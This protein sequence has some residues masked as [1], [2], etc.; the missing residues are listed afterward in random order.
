MTQANKKVELYYRIGDNPNFSGTDQWL[1]AET[2]DGSNAV[3]YFEYEHSLHKPAEARVTLINSIP[4]FRAADI[5]SKSG[6]LSI[7]A[8]GD[9]AA[10]NS[11]LFIW[12]N[13]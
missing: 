8:S 5:D 10:T 7:L 9:D 6:K 2:Q 12:K 4:N 13:I 1:R 3:T 11:D